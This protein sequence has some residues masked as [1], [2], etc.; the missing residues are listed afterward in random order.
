MSPAPSVTQQIHGQVPDGRDVNLFTL[1]GKTHTL[2]THNEPG[3]IPCHLH[4]IILS[5]VKKYR[6]PCLSGPGLTGLLASFMSG[7]ASF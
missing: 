3:G 5:L 1:N 7:M 4:G 2:A 6:P